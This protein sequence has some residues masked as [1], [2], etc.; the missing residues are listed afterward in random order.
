MM[1]MMVFPLFDGAADLAGVVDLAVVA[2]GAGAVD[3]ADVVGGASE[4]PLFTL[5][6]AFPA[7][8]PSAS[9]PVQPHDLPVQHETHCRAIARMLKVL[10][11]ADQIARVSVCFSTDKGA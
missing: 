3:V 8:A 10:P 1:M 7:S 2:A 4:F 9:R 6:L 11:S 5:G